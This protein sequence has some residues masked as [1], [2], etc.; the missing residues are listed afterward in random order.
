MR[1]NIVIVKVAF[2]EQCHVSLEHCQCLARFIRP[3]SRVLLSESV[4][5][6]YLLMCNKFKVKK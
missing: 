5:V 1:W 2:Y 6:H 3:V 4:I